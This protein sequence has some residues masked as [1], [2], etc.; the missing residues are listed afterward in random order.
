MGELLTPL[1]LFHPEFYTAL[2][3]TRPSCGAILHLFSRP[4]SRASLTGAV[5][6][7][8]LGTGWDRKKE[9]ISPA[10]TMGPDGTGRFI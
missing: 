7:T 6:F 10:K 8:A 5:L 1:T 4:R 3:E 9:K 2:W